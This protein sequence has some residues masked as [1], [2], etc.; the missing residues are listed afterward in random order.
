MSAVL[1]LLET[2]C[3]VVEA[4]S[5]NRAAEALHLS[6]PA[7]TK[8]I[9]ALEAELGVTLLVRGRQG[10]TL[11]PV[12]RRI[13]AL[14]RRAVAAA[15]A[16]R[17]AAREWQEPGS[18]GVVVGAGLTLTLFTLPPVIA[19][20]RRQ[21]PGTRV[22]VRTGTSQETLARLLAYE[23]DLAFVTSP[24]SHP[25]VR[26]QVLF[27]DPL[28]LAAAPP[29]PAGEIHPVRVR[30]LQGRTLISFRRGSGL[31]QYLDQVLEARGVRPEVVMEF[32]SIEAIKTM[33][34]L[35][36]G[37]ALLPWSAVRADAEAG[38]I[39]AYPLA[40]WP[41]A[42]RQISMIWRR[43]AYRPPTVRAFQTLA[44]Q[45]LRQEPETERTGS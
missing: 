26:T 2:F 30:D 21:F 19:A 16:C 25:E 13:H 43:D 6:Q 28:V 42:G 18:T 44:R 34:A 29:A 27:T 23:V 45:L 17:R 36:L 7:V 3:A 32:D 1:R 15:E 20:F 37:V 12:G 41:D 22:E 39:V 35:D 8:Q 38:R 11:T 5:L 31:R 14:A 33:V 4:G 9:R 24:V 10:V 40:D